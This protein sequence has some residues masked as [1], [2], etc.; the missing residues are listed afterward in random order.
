MA[1]GYGHCF[2]KDSNNYLCEIFGFW[3]DNLP[4]YG[5]ED[6]IEKEKQGKSINTY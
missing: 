1:N 4:L 5:K 2:Y 6:Y 3:K